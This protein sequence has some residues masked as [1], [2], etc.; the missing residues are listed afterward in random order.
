M[1]KKAPQTNT[2][3]VSATTLRK[4][5]LVHFWRLLI[6]MKKDALREIRDFSQDR[7][8]ELSV[9]DNDQSSEE[10]LA[11]HSADPSAK[12]KLISK[13][14]KLIAKIEKALASIKNGTYGICTNCGWPISEKRLEARPISD[15]CIECKGEKERKER[16]IIGGNGTKPA[17]TSLYEYR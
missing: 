12:E 1:A 13:Q 15:L 17:R 9:A 10:R 3:R 4:E 6:E 5:R 14:I 16:Q 2:E 8:E 7:K 11:N